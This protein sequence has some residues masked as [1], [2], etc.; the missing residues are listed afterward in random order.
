M[1]KKKTT[2]K[3][4]LV[5][6]KE[7]LPAVVGVNEGRGFDDM[8]QDD[9]II[10]YAK[11]MQPLS[12]EVQDDEHAAKVGDI[13]NS[14]TGHVYGNNIKFVPIVFQKRRIK[15]IPRDNG[16]GMECASNNAQFPDTAEMFAERCAACPFS[17]WQKDDAGGPLAPE[18][19]LMYVFP[20]IVV[21]KVDNENKLIA[22]SFGKTSFKAGK[23][24]VNIARMAGG[25]IFSKPYT[26]TTHKVKNDKGVF[27]V[28]DAEMAGKLSKED[29]QEAEGYF[30]MLDN[31]KYKLHDEQVDDTPV[32]ASSDEEETPF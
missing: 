11:L 23:R 15:W 24:L 20:A 14:L 8:D 19:D 21:G 9:L 4:D 29:Y 28:L 26:L 17:K 22:I 12:P 25:D 6:S 18:C 5:V 32:A 10:P 27:F 16:G 3:T 2:T 13:V 31:M 30:D 1:P 7:Q